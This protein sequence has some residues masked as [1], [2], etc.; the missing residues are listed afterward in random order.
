M[1]AHFLSLTMVEPDGAI[2]M[3]GAADDA[4]ATI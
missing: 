2:G 1:P 3:A 4:G